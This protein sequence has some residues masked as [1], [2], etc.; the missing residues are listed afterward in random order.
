MVM[1]SDMSPRRAHTRS[2]HPILIVI[3]I[4]ALIVCGVLLK[5]FVGGLPL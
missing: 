1:K 3:A 5:L 2:F 4:N